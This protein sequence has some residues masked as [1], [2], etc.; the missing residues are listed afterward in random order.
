M[1]AR[2]ERSPVSLKMF[3]SAED[4]VRANGC[5]TLKS[6]QLASEFESNRTEWNKEYAD[7]GFKGWENG[8]QSATWLRD[9]A[10]A[11]APNATFMVSANHNKAISCVLYVDIIRIL[12]FIY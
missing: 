4:S 1:A 6:A 3:M 10:E 12:L 9:V 5:K 11:K 8:E 2:C 7:S